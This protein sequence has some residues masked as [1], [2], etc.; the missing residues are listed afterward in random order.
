L[1]RDAR[2]LEGHPAAAGP[3]GSGGGR[4]ADDAGA[5]V[6]EASEGQGQAGRGILGERPGMTLQGLIAQA[7]PSP[8]WAVF[9]EVSNATGWGASRR[10]DAVAL[11]VWPSR[12]QMLIGFEFKTAR[13]DW[14]NERKNPAKAETIAAHCDA[15]YVV[16][17]DE[18]VVK[19]DELPEPWGL[20]VAN[21]DNTKFL[22]K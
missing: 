7:Y 9:Y 19:L 21:K 1:A 8:E 5:A 2:S 15:W 3:E 12:G 14:L 18:S 22:S 6:K 4:E 10:A 13:G 17:G 20:H 11:G 16:A